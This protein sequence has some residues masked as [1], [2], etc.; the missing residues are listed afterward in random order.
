[1]IRRHCAFDLLSPDEPGAHF[2]FGYYDKSPYSVDGGRVLCHRSRFAD[3]FPAPGEPADVGFI[4]VATP[5]RPFVKVGE[6]LAW[7]W[8]QG[9]ML[10]WFGDDALLFND[11]RPRESGGGLV[12]RVVGLDG[13]ERRCFPA[14][15]LAVAPDRSSALTL[16]VGRLTDQRF[17]YGYPGER[18]VN[19]G[20]AAPANDGVYRVDLDTGDVSLI[21]PLSELRLGSD[22]A[23]SGPEPTGY[24]NHL[25]Y[26]RSASRFCFVHR[27]ERDDGITQTR[28]FTADAADGSGLRRLMTG[29]VSHYDWRDDETILAWAGVRRLLGSGSSGR[30]SPKARLMTAARRAL[31]PVYYALGKPRFLMNRI[32]GDRYM[33]IDDVADA[34]REGRVAGWASGRLICDGHC[35]YNRGGSEPNRWVVTDGYPDRGKQPLFVWDTL[36]DGGFEVGRFTSP[37]RYDKETRVDLHPRWNRDATRICIDSAMDGT[38]RMYEVDVSS[39]TRHG[40]EAP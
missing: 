36:T 24:V 37:A 33:L 15:L 6:T 34:D 26:N 10:Q 35:T 29:M 38:R 7:N 40:D 25:M 21:V 32:V 16:G 1:M 22:A 20:V 19:A 13:R 4:D 31:K 12:S 2:W 17:E 27:Y 8:Q 11:R 23:W 3:R 39:I 5:G 28:L 14:A 9:A 30:S 18:D